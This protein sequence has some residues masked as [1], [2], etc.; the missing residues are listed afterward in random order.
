MLRHLKQLFIFSFGNH[1]FHFSPRF[2]LLISL[3]TRTDQFVALSWNL[4]VWT[5]KLREHLEGF[6]AQQMPTVPPNSPHLHH[7]I[8]RSVNLVV[9]AAVRHSIDNLDGLFLCTA[10]W[11]SQPQEARAHFFSIRLPQLG[12]A[13][14]AAAACWVQ[15]R[16]SVPASFWSR[17]M[18]PRFC[19]WRRERGVKWGRRRGEV[20]G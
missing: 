9:P 19:A 5:W 14:A 4:T 20:G 17:R 6:Q 11:V 3:K 15:T 7:V 1:F 13:A 10:V 12:E 16:L 8:L 18:A 2:L